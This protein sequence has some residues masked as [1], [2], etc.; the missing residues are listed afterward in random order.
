M[1]IFVVAL[2]LR[3][4]CDIVDQLQLPFTS[5]GLLGSS[6]DLFDH[7]LDQSCDHFWL[8]LPSPVSIALSSTISNTSAPATT[9]STQV[10]ATFAAHITTKKYF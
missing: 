3:V 6:T 9:S 10:V 7:I 8:I 4:S 2:A 5:I 1:F